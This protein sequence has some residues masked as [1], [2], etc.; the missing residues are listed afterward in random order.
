MKKI[1][2]L[3]LCFASV[4]VWG[5][6]PLMLVKPG[7]EV[8][9]NFPSAILP[10]KAVTV[11]LP[12]PAVPLHQKYPVVY[13]LGV[14]PKDA[15]L[16]QEILEK[17][18]QKA[19]LV[20]L[21]VEEADLADPA[22]I[23][24]FFS[25]ELVPYIDTNYLTK[26]EPAF[27]AIAAYGPSGTKTAAALLARKQLF[28]R[29]LLVNSGEEAISFAGAD[30]DLRVLA[31]G[32]RAELTVL[33]QT[34]QEM[35]LPYG[36]QVALQM[37]NKA[38]LFANL[39]LEYLFAKGADLAVDKLEGEITPKTLFITPQEQARADFRVTLENG[40]RF[41]YIPLDLR[42]APPYLNW[43]AGLGV[44]HPVPGASAGKV[45]ISVFVDKEKFEGKIKLKK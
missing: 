36:S 42:I 41:D 19:I 10:D 44:L 12:E 15:P 3:A 45:K 32:N 16:A 8:F 22:K 30:K 2:L 9:V 25:Q 29:A 6:E 40:M 31:A 1:I 38:S 13:L 17:S 27:R 39:N 21:N 11:F 23:V 24:Q 28:G 7:R 26:D 43:N 5:A 14:W 33:W 4:C 34:L 20:G 35:G 37:S 18:D